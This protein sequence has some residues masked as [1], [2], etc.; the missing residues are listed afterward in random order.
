MAR[1]TSLATPTKSKPPT[2]LEDRA[3]RRNPPNHQSIPTSPR[4]RPYNHPVL[5][6]AHKR[7]LI[8]RTR[9]QASDL[10]AHLKALGA[11]PILIPTIE[12]VPPATYASLDAALAQLNAPGS[13]SYDWLLFTSANAV[14]AF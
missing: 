2:L 11:T 5:P 13:K 6:L 8:T 10:A 1:H 9:H 12:I 4:P 7:V 14:E 3:R